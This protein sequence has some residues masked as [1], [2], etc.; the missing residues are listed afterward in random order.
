MEFV[1][2]VFAAFL[3]PWVI[4]GFAAQFIFFGRFVIQW[5][6]S[7][8]TG[9]VTIPRSFWYLSIVGAIMI[10]IY[11]IHR[12]DIVFIAGQLIALAIYLR[13]LV[14]DKKRSKSV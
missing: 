9:V 7:E 11:A 10:L 3:D 1:V 8:R 12:E 5:L 4:F 14:L 6:A 2:K 13:N